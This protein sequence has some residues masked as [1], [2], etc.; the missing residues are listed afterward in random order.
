[1]MFRDVSY[2]YFFI[3]GVII[4][5]SR[6]LF[7]LSAMTKFICFLCSTFLIR[8]S[9]PPF[10]F[11]RYGCYWFVNSFD[12]TTGTEHHNLICRLQPILWARQHLSAADRQ[13]SRFKLTSCNFFTSE[14]KKKSVKVHSIKW[15]LCGYMLCIHNSC[16]CQAVLII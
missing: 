6:K 13:L 15:D 4:S 5:N 2:F 7:F 11:L 1:M 3:F 16:C 9:R 8:L 10:L 12:Q 14:K